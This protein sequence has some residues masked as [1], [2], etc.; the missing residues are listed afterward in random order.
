[1]GVGDGAGEAV[2]DGVT[3]LVTLTVGAGVVVAVFVSVGVG[4]EHMLI[5][6]FSRS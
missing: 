4:D 1:V 5:L 2:N 3:V 6:Y